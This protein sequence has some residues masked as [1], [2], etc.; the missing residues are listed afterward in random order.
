MIN[1]EKFSFIEE[2]MKEYKNYSMLNYHVLEGMAD[3]VRVIDKEGTIIYANKTMKESLGQDL[4]GRKCY[5][6]IGKIR[7]CTFCITERSIATGD[8]V[9]KEEIVG[10]RVFSVKSSPVADCEGNI[11]A[12]V[13]VFRDVTRER[14]LEREIKQ[15]N[16][17]MS[18]D[19]G[20]AKTLQRKI[21]P[22]R[23]IYKNVKIDFLYKPCEML[24]GDMFDIFYIDDQHIGIYI[25]DVAGHGITASMMTMF[26]RQTMRA[27]K[28]EIKSP[29]KT[30]TELHKRF[31]DLDLD[32]DKYFTMF[33]GVINT[34]TNEF[35]YSNAGHNCVPI[36]FNEE[37]IKILKVRGFPISYIFNEIKY[38]EDS[39][40]L[41]K[42]DEI[43]FYTDGITEIQNKSKKEFGM[44]GVIEV[45]EKGTANVIKRL[46]REVNKFNWGTQDDDLAVVL[47]EV[48]E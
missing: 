43:L 19:L 40:K 15:K 27:I 1:K 17:K 13:E 45:I 4:E 32:D 29:A 10:D 47:I 42:G 14:K 2:K 5:E 39:I 22:Q 35:R 38:K 41:N 3:W 8:I 23:G 46:E 25:S 20:F 6:A 31:I 11:Y 37:E 21:L 33:Y 16:K 9:Q 7:P 28:E 12:A 30:L 26:V 36:L 18:K 34:E 44:E 24:S 48:M